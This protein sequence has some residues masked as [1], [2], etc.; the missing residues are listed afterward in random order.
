MSSAY[1]LIIQNVL[2]EC[3]KDWIQIFRKNVEFDIGPN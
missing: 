1:V 3:Q 2:S